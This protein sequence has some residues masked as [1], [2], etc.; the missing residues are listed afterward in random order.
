MFF[1]KSS[2]MSLFFLFFLSIGGVQ[3]C[4]NYPDISSTQ[5]VENISKKEWQKALKD[6]VLLSSLAI[7]GTHD[8]GAYVSGGAM[9]I[10][11]K[12]SVEEQLNEGIRAFDIRLRAIDDEKMMIYHGIASQKITFREDVL[13]TCINFLE[14]HPREFI[15]MSLKKEG[16][17]IRSPKGY[18]GLLRE[19]IENPD[20]KNLFVKEFNKNLTIG[21]LRGKILL[22]HRSDIGFPR[23]GGVFAGWRDDASFQGAI[24]GNNSEATMYVEDEYKV[25]LV[26]DIENKRKSIENNLIHSS[27]TENERDWFITFVSGTG[28]FAYPN[29]VAK[30]IN[31]K[32]LD[33][34]SKNENEKYRGIIFLDFIEKEDPLTTEIIKLNK[35]LSK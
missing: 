28:V 32:L 20:Y 6:S 4:S 15:V 24:L 10:T 22:L 19:I 14:Q 25:P 23:I 7:P 35:H 13:K 30:K 26:S 12:L 5:S 3:N 16:D 31:P 1:I 34:L 17:D 2:F 11:Q 33:F 9:I 27:K 29:I 21:N 8:T 18:S